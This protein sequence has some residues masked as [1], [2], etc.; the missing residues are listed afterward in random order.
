MRFR[1]WFFVVLL[2]CLYVAADSTTCS[3]TKKCEQGCCNKSG[4]CGFGPDY[5]G[6]SVCRSDCDR[7]AECNP[8]FG[9]KWAKSD[10][11]PLNVCCS[12]HG[13]C[14]TTKD[15]CGTKTVKRPSCEK[16]DDMLRVV[17]YFESWAKD[18]PCEVFNPEDIPI[19]L[20]THINFAFGS[21][22]PETFQLEAN[23]PEDKLAY[24]RLTFLKKRDKNLKIYLAVGGWTF[25]D[26]GRTAHIF[27]EL[28]ASSIHQHAFQESVESF[29]T[30]YN[31]DGLDLDWEYPVDDK[32]GGR[33][34][35]Y[36][37]FPK[38]MTKLKRRMNI[39]DKGLT[40]TL[41]ASYWY[42]QYFD[43]KNLENT[44]DFF[45][46]MSY[47]LH[48]AWDQ[49][50]NWTQPYL[51]AHTNLTEIESALDL[52][53]RNDISPSKVVMGLGFYGRAF[54]MASGSC[55]EP[56]CLFDGPANMGSCSREKGI[57]LISEID[58]EI[59]RRK[60][61]PKLYKEEAVKVVTWGK[62]WVSYDDE[63]TLQ[64]KVDRAGE[65]CLG[66]VMVWAISHDTKEARYNKALADILGRKTSDA[67]IG[68]DEKPEK[69]VFTPYEQCRWSNCNEPCPK[70]WV[71][72][73]R[74]DKD[75]N[76]KDE[77]M[78][79]ETGCGGDGQHN[80]C[81]PPDEDIP[82]CGWYGHDDGKC[83]KVTSCPSDMVE[84]GS[85]QMY[86]DDKP[87]VQ[88]ACC[89]TTSNSMKA[90]ATCK[91]GEYPE[92]DTDPKCPLEDFPTLV[93]ESGGGSGGL[94]CNG[95][96]NHLGNPVIGVQSRKYCCNEKDDIGFH[97]CKY[98]RDEGPMI[99]GYPSGVCRSNCPSDRV[100][101]A[102]D[103][104]FEVCSAYEVGGQAWC[105]KTK[106]GKK[107]TEYTDKFKD[108]KM[109]M[110]DWMADPYCPAPSKDFKGSSSSTALAVRDDAFVDTSPRNMLEHILGRVGSAAAVAQLTKIW[111]D[112][113][114]QDDVLFWIQITYM[115]RYIRDNWR[116]D[117]QGPAAFAREVLCNPRYW[118]RKIKAFILG[119]DRSKSH[120]LNCTRQG[121]CF[122]D[123]NCDED[124]TSNIERRYASLFGRHSSHFSHSKFHHRSS[125]GSLEPR[126]KETTKILEEDG[127]KH[128]FDIVVPPHTDPTTAS[129]DNPLLD[130][131]AYIASPDPCTDSRV[132]L[133]SYRDIGD[134]LVEL[135]HVLEKA[136]LKRFFV[137]SCL[138]L[139]ESKAAS[140]Y[141]PIPIEFWFQMDN[142]DL[143]QAP[144]APRLPGTGP[145]RARIFERAL[146]CLGS[147]F[148]DE[149]SMIADVDINAAKSNVFRL[150]QFPGVD[151]IEKYMSWTTKAGE[152]KDDDEI[153][154]DYETI[155]KRTR[156]AFSSIEYMNLEEC[157]TRL[158]KI[159][160]D[161]Y[162]QFKFAENVYNDANPPND[163]ADK[164]QLANYWLEWITDYYAHVITTFKKNIKLETDKM[165]EMLKKEDN[166]PA[167]VEQWEVIIDV[168]LQ[169]RD[170]DNRMSL[171]TSGFPAFDSRFNEDED[172]DEEMGG[173]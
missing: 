166:P 114:S 121:L 11:C 94:Q 95:L 60:L 30:T 8:G 67:S 6:E 45:N 119:E 48:G 31:F 161:I 13:Y 171:D 52:L 43:I 148:N 101:V 162:I 78:Y 153:N 142:Y 64:M 34:R 81:C 74:L 79:D 130:R 9:S 108:Y 150:N 90:Y 165:T 35:D 54:T 51:N 19:G 29:L 72:V 42:L 38:F 68:D 70:G 127:E 2:L 39:A 143:S 47:D 21:I 100:R 173:T 85:N 157:V 26:P 137:T 44:V 56:G 99:K 96:K 93:V 107:S 66:G 136:I 125:R 131:V 14:G 57:L 164:V 141:G 169:M 50:V 128:D 10:K 37:T 158:N 132:L 1:A 59:K 156:A 103:W 122:S 168:F 55:R 144:G 49:N 91:W 138:G 88:T 155:I 159:V 75:A 80:F 109:E 160:K 151:S 117:W 140:Q 126:G 58:N 25:N 167:M 53:W 154:D 134:L 82:Q 87:R 84:I 97:D 102:I 147:K 92:C 98:F 15:F 123:G 5:C 77:L 73:G 106:Y 135:E 23:T 124:G 69:E 46:I 104:P 41:P 33:E 4:N 22:N 24:E 71:H 61:K 7:K 139:L 16:G 111:N 3:A 129:D 36:I 12:K 40:I 18:R 172:G 65:R 27:S 20:Y 152:E 118:A 120:L 163:P 17:G 115:S 28:A 86:C 63:E 83:Q 105:C 110:V 133:K 170:D 112:E 146:E 76:S 89:K 116:F 62:Q 113:V 145:A 32:R 149:V